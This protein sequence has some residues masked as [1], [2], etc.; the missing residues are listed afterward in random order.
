MGVTAAL[1]DLQ[2]SRDEARALVR[3]A[4]PKGLFIGR[5]FLAIGRLDDELWLGGAPFPMAAPAPYL[6]GCMLMANGGTVTAVS[7]PAV[8]GRYEPLTALPSAIPGDA[9]VALPQVKRITAR[10]FP[11][12][13]R[14][15]G[16]LIRILSCCCPAT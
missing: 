5:R 9:S 11:V 15:R 4:E 14:V 7:Y 2:A 10:R 13:A 12:S 16:V 8:L 1:I 3:A 6:A